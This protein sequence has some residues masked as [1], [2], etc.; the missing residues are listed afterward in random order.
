MVVPHIAPF[1]WTQ[2]AGQFTKNTLPWS[3]LNAL[4]LAVV[5]HLASIIGINGSL[6]SEGLAIANPPVF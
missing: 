5:W 6:P 1:Y 2:P 3:P 4:Y